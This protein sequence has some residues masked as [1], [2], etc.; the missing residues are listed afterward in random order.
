M[1]IT[2]YNLWSYG[3]GTTQLR[4]VQKYFLQAENQLHV[5]R[6]GCLR[7][8]SLLVIFV[9]IMTI[10][11]PRS[12]QKE[13][14]EKQNKDESLLVSTDDEV[15]TLQGCLSRLQVSYLFHL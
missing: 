1:G 3:N 14:T 5:G 6:I 13:H 12:E 11:K 10:Y 4:Y 8:V 9:I 7:Y 15:C 2:S